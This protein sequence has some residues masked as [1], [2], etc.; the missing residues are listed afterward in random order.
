MKIYPL[1]QKLHAIK[2]GYILINLDQNVQNL[3]NWLK[4]V[5]L[6]AIR[7]F[8]SKWPE[9]LDF[10]YKSY[11]T[12]EKMVASMIGEIT[13]FTPIPTLTITYM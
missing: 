9:I 12:S 3:D 13:N 11:N 10:A 8:G 5:F 1:V 2:V 4:M 6:S 7:H